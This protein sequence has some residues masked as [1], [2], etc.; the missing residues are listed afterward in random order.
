MKLFQFSK[1]PLKHCEIYKD[2]TCCHVDGF[3]CNV[4]TCQELKDYRKDME[5]K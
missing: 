3:L 2:K 4:D 1:D 5:K